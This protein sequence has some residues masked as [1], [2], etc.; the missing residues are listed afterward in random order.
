MI[1]VQP[2]VLKCPECTAPSEAHATHCRYCKVPLQWRPVIS[3]SALAEFKNA[4]IAI[5]RPDEG[6]VLPFG[7]HTVGSDE[8]MVF[9]IQ[10]QLPFRPK[11]LVLSPHIADKVL[12]ENITI[13][14]R[15]QFVSPT[16]IPGW[17][18]RS[19]NESAKIVFD[20]LMVGQIM[21]IHIRSIT[22]EHIG[23][24]GIV[25]GETFEMPMPTF[26]KPRFPRFDDPSH[27]TRSRR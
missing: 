11:E 26:Y 17:A 15:S 19:N 22:P 18:F 14:M 21:T 27:I 12:V 2:F 5:T 4:P 20:P 6:P 8:T 25:R 23:V 10:P 9:Q 3:L 7:P 13:G 1:E 24:S 16:A